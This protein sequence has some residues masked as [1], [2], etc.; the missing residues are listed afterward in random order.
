MSIKSES[1]K[2]EPKVKTIWI[3]P[4]CGW[5][6]PPKGF[7][8]RNCGKCNATLVP[9]IVKEDCELNPA[10]Y[11]IEYTEEYKNRNWIKCRYRKD[12]RDCPGYHS[13]NVN[14]KFVIFCKHDNEPCN[15]KWLGEK[16]CSG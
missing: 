8:S 13:K 14:G 5:V 1:D 2:S 15:A 12:L 7:S 3:C 9:K 16:E 4:K 10:H 11:I 6:R